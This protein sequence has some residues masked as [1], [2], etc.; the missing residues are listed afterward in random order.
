MDINHNHFALLVRVQRDMDIMLDKL[1]KGW[2]VES[3]TTMG[4]GKN[5][6]GGALVV[7]RKDRVRKEDRKVILECKED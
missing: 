5:C 4:A 7:L 6:E 1:D 3:V 2:D